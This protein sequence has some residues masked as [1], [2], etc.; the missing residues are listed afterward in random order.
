MTTVSLIL[1]SF[2]HFTDE[3]L[4]MPRATWLVSRRTGIWTWICLTPKTCL[5]VRDKVEGAYGSWYCETSLLVPK[6]ILRSL[7]PALMLANYFS[8]QTEQVGGMGW[9]WHQPVE[10]GNPTV[11]SLWWNQPGTAP[12]CQLLSELWSSHKPDT[13]SLQ[14][15]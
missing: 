15:W 3:R 10:T 6:I 5:L 1:S 7:V 2:F 13:I 4:E 11:I 14:N 12:T 9:L 8:Q